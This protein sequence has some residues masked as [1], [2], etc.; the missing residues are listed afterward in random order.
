MN[1]TFPP[2]ANQ[3]LRD[4]TQGTFRALLQALARPCSPQALPA[5]PG[6]CPLAPELAQAALTLCDHET[7]V[8]LSPSLD[9]EETRRWL[10]FNTGMQLVADSR[11]AHFLLCA[12]AGELPDM[13]DIDEGTA[14]YPDRSATVLVGGV[15]FASERGVTLR[16]VGMGPGIKDEANLTLCPGDALDKAARLADAQAFC[17]FW[18]AN[19]E[20]FPMGFDL[21]FLGEGRVT[22][23]PRSTAL[24]PAANEENSQCM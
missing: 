15:G 17:D 2:T 6:N 13:D 7:R 10:R 5:Y 4:L 23:L 20:R 14:L 3:G 1:T 9:D 22:G 12:N 21:F 18:Q 19:H 24:K 16:L 11:R 8:W